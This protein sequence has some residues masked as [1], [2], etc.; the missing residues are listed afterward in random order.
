MALQNCKLCP[1]SFPD[2]GYSIGMSW[3]I[4]LSICTLSCVPRYLSYGVDYTKGQFRLSSGV[5]ALCRW[6]GLYRCVW[7]FFVFVF[8]VFGWVVVGFFLGLWFLGSLSFCL[9]CVVFCLLP[10]AFRIIA[11]NTW[12]LYGFELARLPCHLTF[13]LLLSPTHLLTPSHS[14]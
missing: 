7:L 1:Y 14:R 8:V 4:V 11:C 6:S 13:H 5:V 2:L 3:Y 12:V 9:A 10:Y